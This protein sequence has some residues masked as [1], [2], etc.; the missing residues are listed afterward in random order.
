[1]AKTNFFFAS[2]CQLQVTS[3]IALWAFVCWY[4][5]ALN[6]YWLE[7]LQGLCAATVLVNSYVDQF[8]CFRRIFCPWIHLSS[9]ALTILPPP[10]LYY[11]FDSWEE[12]DKG[13]PF[14]IECSKFLI[15]CALSNND[16]LWVLVLSSL[17]DSKFLTL[18]YFQVLSFWRC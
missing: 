5:S 16:F 9:M 1:M 7:P 3:W 14:K 17:S 6:P 11:L 8:C 18:A 15:H 13:S 10:L 4:L 2:V 12:I